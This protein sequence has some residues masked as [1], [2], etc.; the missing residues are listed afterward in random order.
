MLFR[1]IC[2]ENWPAILH[3][4]EATAELQANPPPGSGLSSSTQDLDRIE[5]MWGDLQ[6]PGLASETLRTDEIQRELTEALTTLG[7]QA[8]ESQVVRK[9]LESRLDTPQRRRLY[10]PILQ[11]ASMD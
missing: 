11:Q 6:D 9:M 10:T 5:T 7:D 3:M 4:I 1:S 2:D 8:R